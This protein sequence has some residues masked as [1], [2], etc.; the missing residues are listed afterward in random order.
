LLNAVSLT[1]ASM[2]LM[3]IFGASMAGF[4][5]DF[6]GV[7][8]VYFAI[9][10]VYAVAIFALGRLPPD[11]I[12]NAQ[13]QTNSVW[14][15]LGEGLQY[16]KSRPIIISVLALVVIRVILGWSYT[17]LMPVYA[18]EVLQLGARGLGLLSAAPGLDPCWGL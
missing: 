6:L 3:G 4:V 1:F 9:A 18:T 2:G 16:L 10:M 17:T 13:S 12:N 11:E 7:H 15:D 14:K 5:I 8:A